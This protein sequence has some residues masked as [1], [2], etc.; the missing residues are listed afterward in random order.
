MDIEVLGVV[1]L[2]D[3]SA[4]SQ[5][6]VPFKARQINSSGWKSSFKESRSELPKL[7]KYAKRWKI[8]CADY[9]NWWVG[10]SFVVSSKP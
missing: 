4:I 10:Y 5:G 9:E 1:D 7:P 8:H 2:L 3:H 6:F